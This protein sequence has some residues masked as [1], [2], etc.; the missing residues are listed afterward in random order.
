MPIPFHCIAL[1]R[2]QGKNL[3]FGKPAQQIST[4][5]EGVASKAVDGVRNGNYYDGFC[6]HTLRSKT[7][8]WTVDLGKQVSCGFLIISGITA[9]IL[10]TGLAA[11]TQVKSF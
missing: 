10:A 9:L 4:Y 2:T 7:P 11:H 8:W 6:S 1:P 3:A 5:Q